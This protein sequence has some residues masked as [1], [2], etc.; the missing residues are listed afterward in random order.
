[1]QEEQDR[2]RRIASTHRDPLPNA[3]DLDRVQT[4]DAIRCG[5]PANIAKQGLGSSS[6]ERTVLR[7]GAG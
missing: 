2:I 6:T 1:M 5:D 7:L 4:L 3:A